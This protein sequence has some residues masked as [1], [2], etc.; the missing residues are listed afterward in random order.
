M[1]GKAEYD[2]IRGAHK[3][4]VE[5]TDA[6]LVSAPLDSFDRALWENCAKSSRLSN[7][8]L[9]LVRLILALMAGKG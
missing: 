1:K 5:I 9:F 3:L 8:L 7:K 2:E 6:D 4:V